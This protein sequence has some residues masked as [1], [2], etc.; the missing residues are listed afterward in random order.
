MTSTQTPPKKA[1][2]LPPPSD[3]VFSPSQ[4]PAQETVLR[5][6]FSPAFEQKAAKQ[7]KKDSVVPPPPP[8]PPPRPP[9]RREGALG[10][11]QAQAPGSPGDFWGAE[12][13]ANARAQVQA[14]TTIL[15]NTDSKVEE[16]E[17]RF[18]SPQSFSGE[19]HRSA[20]IMEQ[21]QQRQDAAG[22]GLPFETILT[23][24]E[25]AN[26]SCIN[27]VEDD[28]ELDREVQVINESAQAAA[29]AAAAAAAQETNMVLEVG[30]EDPNNKEVASLN[31]SM[32]P[33]STL[34][35]DKFI[36]TPRDSVAELPSSFAMDEQQRAGSQEAQRSGAA[37]PAQEILQNLSS[38]SIALETSRIEQQEQFLHKLRQLEEAKHHAEQTIQSLQHQVHSAQYQSQSLWEN[39]RQLEVTHE[40]TR[41]TMQN[42]LAQTEQKYQQARVMEERLQTQVA[43]LTQQLEQQHQQQQQTID[44]AMI[45]EREEEWNQALRETRQKL[46][47]MKQTHFEFRKGLERALTDNGIKVSFNRL[48]FLEFKAYLSCNRTDTKHFHIFLR[49]S[50]SSA[51]TSM[52]SSSV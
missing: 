34:Q 39:M 2:V 4:V 1:V 10:V 25:A 33:S 21:Q 15:E 16:D 3:S 30:E 28:E 40:Q 46:E 14:K 43:A 17:E 20:V 32:S 7:R 38:A 48:Y 27:E 37:S 42:D 26:I 8:P 11:E 5:S 9:S 22:G 52:L 24:E 51:S 41:Q 47:K 49:W 29:A 6:I 45:Q 18:F 50:Q 31:F 44:P 13:L 19:D 36:P 23:S 12:E 35:G